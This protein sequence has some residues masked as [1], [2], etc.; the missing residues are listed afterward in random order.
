MISSRQER[1]MVQVQDHR[2]GKLMG[3][4]DRNRHYQMLAQ[5]T[6]I[7]FAWHR[8]VPPRK[9]KICFVQFIVRRLV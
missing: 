8:A 4:R 3:Q 1:S 5:P 9:I 2:R 6:N 7:K